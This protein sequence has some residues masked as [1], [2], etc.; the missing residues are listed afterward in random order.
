M[1]DSIISLNNLYENKEKTNLKFL[2]NDRELN[3]LN[4]GKSTFKN[5]FGLK[6]KKTEIDKLNQN[7]FMVI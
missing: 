4:A 5:M 3:D 7:K 6:S 2:S 1:N